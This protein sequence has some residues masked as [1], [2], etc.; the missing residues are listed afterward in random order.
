MN[1]REKVH[2]A[3]SLEELRDDAPAHALPAEV[4]YEPGEAKTHATWR[5]CP[6]ELVPVGAREAA[7]AFER[8]GLVA[9]GGQ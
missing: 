8:A 7:A 1:T 3:R 4:S 5:K 6:A 9:V 2:I